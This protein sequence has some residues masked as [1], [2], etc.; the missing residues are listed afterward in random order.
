MNK[1][2]ANHSLVILVFVVS[3]GLYQ[4]WKESKN[5]FAFYSNKNNIVE[6]P[7]YMLNKFIVEDTKN[8]YVFIL[9][10]KNEILNY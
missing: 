4:A 6:K 8:K 10:S 1:K 2:V 5:P 9:Y 7:R 3:F